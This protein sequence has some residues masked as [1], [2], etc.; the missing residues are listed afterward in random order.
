MRVAAA[1]PLLHGEIAPPG[2]TSRG[3]LLIGWRTASFL[4]AAKLLKIASRASELASE[5]S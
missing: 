2:T 4:P 1:P 5:S 3:P